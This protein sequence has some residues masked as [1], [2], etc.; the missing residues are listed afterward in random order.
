MT[1]T[2]IVQ[3]AL[4]T[5]VCFSSAQAEESTVI[6][7]SCEGTTKAYVKR[8][9]SVN[10][11]TKM[12][13]AVNLA[14]RTVLFDGRVTHI[15]HI[16]ARTIFFGGDNVK[17]TTGYIDGKTGVMTAM[18]MDGREH[19]ELYELVCP[20][21][22]GAF[23]GLHDI[24]SDSGKVEIKR[25]KK[26]APTHTH[27]RIAP[28]KRTLNSAIGMCCSADGEARGLLLDG[29]GRREVAISH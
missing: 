24:A 1:R 8:E 20:D 18:N 12:G 26:A 4:L 15:D 19:D 10:A 22:V 17:D 6:T 25:H 2:L 5:V 11:V 14:E 3:C 23:S 28:P 13:V 16:H 29:P 7:L 21:A 27:R 9:E